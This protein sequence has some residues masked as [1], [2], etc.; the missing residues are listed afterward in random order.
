MKYIYLGALTFLFF[1]SVLYIVHKDVL[2][3]EEK[4]NVY[5]DSI[6]LLKNQISLLDVAYNATS[7]VK[8]SLLKERNKIHIEYETNTKIYK[9]TDSI[10]NSFSV[11]SIQKFWAKR[12]SKDR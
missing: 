12:Y 4:Q 2:D 7:K 6:I 1:V 8:D 5:K 9:I 10:V 11:D 3:F